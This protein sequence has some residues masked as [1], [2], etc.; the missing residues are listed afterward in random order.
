MTKDLIEKYLKSKI[1]SI[2]KEID[3]KTELYNQYYHDDFY[4][5]GL[6]FNKIPVSVF[7]TVLPSAGPDQILL[8]ENLFKLTKQ[9]ISSDCF[10][11]FISVPVPERQ[12]YIKKCKTAQKFNPEIAIRNKKTLEFLLNLVQDP[13]SKIKITPKSQKTDCIVEII[14]DKSCSNDELFANE[15]YSLYYGFSASETPRSAFNRYYFT[16]D[17]KNAKT[18]PNFIIA[19][20]RMV[21]NYFFRYHKPIIINGVYQNNLPVKMLCQDSFK[22]IFSSATIKNLPIEI[23]NFLILS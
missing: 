8:I 20:D 13:D 21:G 5:F 11:K 16:R 10:K 14:H 12:D 4:S 9:D 6:I 15:W 3:S 2:S 19:F 1:K 22:E 18:Q 23:Q 7:D 17:L